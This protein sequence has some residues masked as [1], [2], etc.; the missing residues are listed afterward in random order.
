MGNDWL[1]AKGALAQLTISENSHR[2]FKVR[3]DFQ[4]SEKCRREYEIQ[5]RDFI[6]HIKNNNYKLPCI[7]CS[8]TTKFSGRNNPNTKYTGLD[9]N[10]FRDI[11]SPEKAYILGWI[12]SDGHISSRGF[13]INIHQKDG[14]TLTTLR[15]II[16]SEV[17]ISK[18]I[19]SNG[20]HMND[21]D[22]NSVNI[23][24]D[25]CTIFNIKPGK[26]SDTIGFPILSDNLNKYFLRGYFEGDGT[27]NNRM[28]S[29]ITYPKC[30]IRSD[31]TKMLMG[32]QDNLR[33][34]PS[35][36]Y[37]YNLEFCA[38]ESIMFLDYIY[39]DIFNDLFLERKYNLYLDWKNNY[40]FYSK[41]N[42]L[43]AEDSPNS[44]LNWAQVKKI[45]NLFMLGNSLV[46]IANK[47]DVSAVNIA[48][49]IQNK[50]WIDISYTPQKTSKIKLTMSDA[51]DIR[52]MAENGIPN[53][54]IAK[55]FGIDDTTVSKIKHNKNWKK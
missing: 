52:K 48:N 36:I 17:P 11:D 42:M 44:K 23:S 24:K 47:Y 38:R 20:S 2:L 8:R 41:K 28:T 22:I 3:C 32:I 45:R 6:K 14:K 31:S 13:T 29:Y 16:C 54:E 26:K 25:L 35:K 34:I 40:E 43:R 55:K 49:I 4:V 51:N 39:S 1:S 10:F 21:F 27:L 30:S 5:Y 9:D 19:G 33:N 12:G 37:N 46:E 7:Y 15:N 50:T 53:T 18:F